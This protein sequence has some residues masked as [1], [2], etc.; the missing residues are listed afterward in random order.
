MNIDMK[1]KFRRPRAAAEVGAQDL[2]VM[3]TKTQLPQDSSAFQVQATGKH[4]GD[5]VEFTTSHLFF[6]SIFTS[7][8]SYF[9][10]LAG[11]LST[12]RRQDSPNLT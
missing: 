6:K 4:K 10:T 3:T 12:F 7:G 1:N 9:L 8:F 2:Q 5:K 11:G